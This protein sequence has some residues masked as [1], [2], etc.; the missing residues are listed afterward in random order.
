MEE[1]WMVSHLPKTLGQIMLTFLFT[2]RIRSLSRVNCS[3]VLL[4]GAWCILLSYLLL[5]FLKSA[6]E[7]E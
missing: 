1:C 7:K 3:A 2:Y 5:C 4:S 6:C